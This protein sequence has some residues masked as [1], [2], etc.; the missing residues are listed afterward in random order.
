[1][2]I[3]Y[4]D[5]SDHHKKTMKF[6]WENGIDKSKLQSFIVFEAELDGYC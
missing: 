2:K 4:I 1:M 3:I 5:S 6:W